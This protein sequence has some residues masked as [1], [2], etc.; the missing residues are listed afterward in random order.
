MTLSA[1]S[2]L[3][4]TLRGKPWGS[5]ISRILAASLAA[6]DPGVAIDLTLKRDGNLLYTAGQKFNL[7]D[8][9]NLHILSIGK[10]GIPMAVAVADLIFDHLTGGAV[11]TKS[12]GSGIPD[13]FNGKIKLY[14]GGHPIPNQDSLKS[15][16]EILSYFSDQTKDDLVIVLISGGGSALFT[17]PAPGI[18]LSDI[19]QAN[20]IFLDHGLTIQEINTIRKHISQIKGGQLAE[21]L[22]PART[23]TLIL[24]DVVGDPMDMIASGPTVPDPT[25]YA[26]ALEIISKYQLEQYLPSSI[27]KHL[28]DRNESKILENPKP[29][30]PVF[31]GQTSIVIAGI[32][33]A[34]IG[35]LKQ[36]QQEGFQSAILPEP[37]AGE[38]KQVGEKLAEFLCQSSISAPQTPTCLIAGGETTVT[39]TGSTKPGKGGRNLELS[40]SAVKHL[41]GRKDLALVTLATDGEDGVTDAAGSIVTGQTLARAAELGL[42]PDDF[43]SNHDSYAFFLALDDLLMPGPTGTNVN[44]LCFLFNF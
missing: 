25:T 34:L 32:Q 6:V 30:D 23:I 27:S 40:L 44:D 28:M 8:F 19:Q 10:A 22:H 11:L 35:G 26:D 15:T 33:D 9:K 41:A 1:E 21:L 2:F 12:V 5:K 17:A 43:L 14:R 24:S 38:A 3:T 36:A 13:R 42:N 4:R 16:A 18:S 39:L 29:G 7:D 37:L 20:Q 31:Q